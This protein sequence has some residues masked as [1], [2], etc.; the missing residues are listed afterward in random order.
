MQCGEVSTRNE[1]TAFDTPQ[2]SFNKQIND[3]EYAL[4]H[5]AGPLQLTTDCE[6]HTTKPLANP[7]IS[8]VRAIYPRTENPLWALQT[9]LPLGNN[10]TLLCDFGAMFDSYGDGKW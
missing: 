4:D 2:A 1:K 6:N 7:E 5:Y 10:G 8:G 9:W 3:G